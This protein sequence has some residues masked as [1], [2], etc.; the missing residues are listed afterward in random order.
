MD[1]FSIMQRRSLYLNVLYL[2]QNGRML[3]ANAE[4]RTDC[5]H[6]CQ[7]EI[8]RCDMEMNGLRNQV[9]GDALLSLITQPYVKNMNF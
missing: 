5:I 3:F 6:L 7:D 2:V 1:A 8:C 9:I 4:E